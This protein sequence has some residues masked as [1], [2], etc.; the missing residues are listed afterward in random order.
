LERPADPTTES[1]IA[2]AR[3]RVDDAFDATLGTIGRTL[4]TRLAEAIHPLTSFRDVD[5]GVE[6]GS[7]DS[8]M[9]VSRMKGR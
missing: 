4:E 5:E 3:L 2:N 7:L 1:Q 8:A 9:L 6:F